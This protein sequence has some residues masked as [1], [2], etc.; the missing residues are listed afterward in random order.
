[1]GSFGNPACAGAFLMGVGLG[2][3]SP[4]GRKGSGGGQGTTLRHSFEW[5]ADPTS[6]KLR[7]AG[8]PIMPICRRIFHA[9]AILREGG[10][11]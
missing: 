6:Q 3:Q 5:Q 11:F 1:L 4:I 9:P 10:R 8:R 2:S 7:R